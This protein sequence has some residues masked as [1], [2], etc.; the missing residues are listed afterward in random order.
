MGL[1]L[2]LDALPVH[3]SDLQAVLEARRCLSGG[4]KH[5]GAKVDDEMGG[6][7]LCGWPDPSHPRGKQP[8]GARMQVALNGVNHQLCLLS[9]GGRQRVE[10]D[11]GSGCGP[12]PVPSCDDPQQSPAGQRASSEAAVP[13]GHAQDV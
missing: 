8:D 9:L 3:V 11:H 13:Q 2:L 4:Q 10:A 1:L 12:G 6:P 7:L 5:V